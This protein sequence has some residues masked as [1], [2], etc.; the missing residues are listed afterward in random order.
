MKSKYKIIFSDLLKE[1]KKLLKLSDNTSNSKRKYFILKWWFYSLDFFLQNEGIKKLNLIDS[2]KH[3]LPDKVYQFYL[4][5]ELNYVKREKK[6]VY[7]NS[8]IQ[9]ILYFIFLF[10]KIK[11]LSFNRANTFLSPLRDRVSHL[12]LMYFINKKKINLN[13][14]SKFIFEKKITEKKCN[15]ILKNFLIR[16]ISE[17]FF[18]ESK[19]YQKI[20]IH[21]S[22]HAII[23][24]EF[25]F[26]LSL[27]FN[28]SIII[29]YQHG[30][31]YGEY[32]K[33]PIHDI[34]K[35]ISDKFIYWFPIGKS[36]YI[37]RFD[38]KKLKN[39]SN[40]KI[41]W[42]GSAI[43]CTYE[44]LIEGYYLKNTVQSKRFIMKLDNEFK[45]LKNFFYVPHKRGYLFKNIKTKSLKSKHKLENFI[46]K[47]DIIIF[48]TISSTLIYY[49][50]KNDIKFFIITDRDIRNIR[51]I[52]KDYKFFLLSL[53][54]KNFLFYLSELNIL[55]EKLKKNT[56]NTGHI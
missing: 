56:F 23:H 9:K 27:F 20:E 36:K 50:L 55:I 17:L 11:K 5:K 35:K 44:K 37:G 38:K 14:R 32:L 42:V 10:I 15:I 30:A 25:F 34:E 26:K 2:K 43:T 40:Y 1:Y 7:R 53:R 4:K 52:S 47:N 33:A 51:G 31:G 41:Y 45:K 19:I 54:K 12:Y 21:L 6:Y 16:N 18:L 46:Q 13:L 8:I 24:D 28:N 49:C 3:I 29:G 39:N 22:P 48:D